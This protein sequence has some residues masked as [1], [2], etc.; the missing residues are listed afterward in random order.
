[1]KC[2]NSK[3]GSIIKKILILAGA[4]VFLA[5]I[6]AVIVKAV[7]TLRCDCDFDDDFFGDELF[8]DDDEDEDEDTETENNEGFAHDQDFEQP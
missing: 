1:M 7:K 8:D 2:C 5:F 3:D 6:A 4:A